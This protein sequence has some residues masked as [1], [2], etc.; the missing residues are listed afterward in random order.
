MHFFCKAG[1]FRV[2]KQMSMGKA[3]VKLDN[4]DKNV[5]TP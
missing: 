3:G 4:P 2:V 5:L 1:E